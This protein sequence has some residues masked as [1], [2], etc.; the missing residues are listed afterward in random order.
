[1][2]DVDP[3]ELTRGSRYR[4]LSIHSRDSTLETRG[5]YLG[6][7]SIGHDTGLAIKLDDGYDELSGHTRIIP[8]HMLV[9]IDILAAQVKEETEEGP[10]PAYYG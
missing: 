10:E 3:I 7:T 9:S 4:V 2:S 5:I 1:M 8:I 6:I